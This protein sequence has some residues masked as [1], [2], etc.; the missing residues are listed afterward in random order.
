M[1]L[2]VVLV[3]AAVLCAIQV[4]RA[5]RLIESVLWLA[6]VSVLTAILLFAMDAS[7]VSAIELSVGAGL[8][9][10]IFVFAIGLAGELTQDL[11]SLIPRPLALGMAIIA[12]GWLG[13][14]AWPGAPIE[15]LGEPT[16]LQ[17]VFWEIRA[18]DVWVQVALILAGVLG[19]L[20]LGVDAPEPK[21][22]PGDK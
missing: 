8:V 3:V 1:W 16:T 18:L 14:L 2:Y 15:P 12:V 6:A 19:I 5:N 21:P 13:W 10:V 4:V 7:L 17:A 9:T 20:N 22:K 11:P